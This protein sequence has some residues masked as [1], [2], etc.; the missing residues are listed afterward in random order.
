VEVE[1]GELVVWREIGR[2]G[3]NRVFLND[4]PVTCACSP[5]LLV[6][7]LRIHGQ[8]EELA[9]TPDLQRAWLDRSGGDEAARCRG[10]RAGARRA[11]DPGGAPRARAAT[12]D[13]APSGSTCC[14]SR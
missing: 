13:C 5:S 8:R 3:R 4:Q 6:A 10:D 9:A 14:G 11:G 1:G 2:E 12:R 7:A